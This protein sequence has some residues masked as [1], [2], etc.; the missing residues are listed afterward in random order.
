MKKSKPG[1]ALRPICAW[2]ALAALPAAY[3]QVNVL[4][5][6]N[7]AGRTGQNLLE[8]VLTPANVNSS[9]FGKLFTIPVDGGVDAEPLY[10]SAL[11]FPSLGTHNVLYVVTENDSMYAFDADSGVQLWQISLL[12]T[13]ESPS[14]DRG[15]GQVSP[16]IGITSTPVIDLASGPHGTIYAVAMSKD[17]SGNYHQRLHAIDLVTHAEEF[18]GPMQ[19]QATYPGTGAGSSGGTVIFDPKQYKDR[20]GLLIVNGVVYTSWASHCDDA[21]YTAWVIGY[22]ESTLAQVTVL[23]LT[24]NG[25]DGSVWQAGAGPAADAGGNLFFL[26]ANGTFDTKLTSSGF[27][28]KGDYGNAFM[29]LSTSG[30]LAVADY[31][32]MTNTVSESNGDED[33]GSGGAMVLPTVNDSTGNPRSLAVGAGK[34]ANVYV[35]DRNNMG[36]FHP[37][38]DAIYQQFTLGGGVWSSPAWFNGVLYYGAVGD[39]LKA[40]PFTNG[41]F[42]TTPSSESSIGFTYP[43]TT[44]SISANGS[45]QGIVWA[46]ENQSTAVLHAYDATDLSTELYNSNQAPN[47]RDQFGSGNKFITP[48]VANGKVYVGTS[49]GVGVLG[50]L[51]CVYSLTTSSASI[52]SGG[53]TGSFNLT[54][55]SGCA[56]S[57]TD[58]TG[59]VTITSGASGTGNGTISYSV[60]ADTG[61]SRSGVLTVGGQSFTINQ[62][63]AQTTTGLAFYPLTPCRIA[64]TRSTGGSGKTGAFGPPYLAGGSTRDFPIPSSSCDVPSTAQAYSLNVTVVP[65]KPLA[66]LTVWPAGVTMPPTLTLAASAGQIVASAAIT[67]AG[68]GGAISVYAGSDTDVI[69]DING[70]FAPPAAQGL[71]FYPMPPCRIADTR[72]VG[73]SGK[74]GK[75]GPPALA[76]RGTRN[77]PLLSSSCGIPSSAQAYSL[78]MTV[79]PSGSLAYLTTWPAGDA[80]PLVSTLNDLNGAIVANAAIVPAGA[81]GAIDVSAYNQTNLIID[82]DGYFA[83]PGTQ[84]LY[85]YPLGPCRVADT[86]AGS[87]LTG[88]FGP[89]KLTGGVSR[90]FPVTSSACNVPETAQGYA[91]S[92]TVLP[93]GAMPYL[94]VWPSGQAT[95]LVSTLN[96]LSGWTVANLALVPAGASGAVSVFAYSSTNLLMDI[97]GYF[98]P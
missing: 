47:S 53:G 8:T 38:S 41:A 81:S 13:G 5:W 2:L 42:S 86:R 97:S 21:P 87:S 16:E 45:A 59:F 36:K 69:L 88:S 28:S 25:N 83:P 61:T 33:L 68:T 49:N 34:D 76:A 31:F 66:Q 57:V 65:H 70:Y 32:T 14:D 22:N 82:I 63:G 48:M 30:G 62:A 40:F 60:S 3:G 50:L 85:Y 56:W 29:K 77:F 93:T 98:A 11:T 96:D 19:V 26:M 20:A 51:G 64:D 37:K 18:N 58:P 52:A 39:N 4:T 1:F 27:P 7:D 92:L 10:V 94:T 90:D 54:T 55:A 72:S 74:T 73:G 89:P 9:T 95:P 75:F 78:N 17:N 35:V 12:E 79:V 67:A 15:C 84:G 24:P 6:H 80:E 23:D 91:L 46:V 71:A 43:G 44:P